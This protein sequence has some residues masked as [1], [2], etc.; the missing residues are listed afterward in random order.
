MITLAYLTLPAWDVIPVTKADA[1]LPDGTCKAILIG[2]AGTLNVEM[3]G[4]DGVPV[5]RNSLPLEA[6]LYPF[7]CT[8][9]RTGGTADS[10]FAVY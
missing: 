3:R 6:G 2:T 5:V 7:Q 9:I 8:Q 4:I 1:N 10:I